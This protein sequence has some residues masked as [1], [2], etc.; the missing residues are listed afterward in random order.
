MDTEELVRRM[1]ELL[2]PS[3]GK[4]VAVLLGAGELGVIPVVDVLAQFPYHHY[5]LIIADDPEQHLRHEVVS[6]LGGKVPSTPRETQEALRAAE[7]VLVPVVTRTVLSKVALGI[8]D[9]PVAAGMAMALLMGKEVI[10]VRDEYDPGGLPAA[11]TGLTANKVYNAMLAGYE[12]RLEEFGVKVIDLSEFRDT[13][14]AK[15]K[16]AV[17]QKPVFQENGSGCLPPWD[18]AG[19]SAGITGASTILTLEDVERLAARGLIEQA[20]GAL[21]TPSAREYLQSAQREKNG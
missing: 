4:K 13:L 7:L 21:L 19:G 11:K 9:D 16:A 17:L 6:R 10:A 8:Q 20:G 2:L 12:R 3:L 14:A 15:S 5:S 18:E 1:L